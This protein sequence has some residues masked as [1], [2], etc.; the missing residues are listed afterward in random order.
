VIRIV[1]RERFNAGYLWLVLFL[2]DLV[3]V[4]L[5]SLDPFVC[6]GKDA[7]LLVAGLRPKAAASLKKIE[8]LPDASSTESL[9]PVQVA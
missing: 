8:E 2:E 6:M 5:L 9:L 4:H 7:N 1:S 3:A